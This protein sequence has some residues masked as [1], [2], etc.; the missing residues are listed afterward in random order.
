MVSC[1][2]TLCGFLSTASRQAPE[3]NSRDF[4]SRLEVLARTLIADVFGTEQHPPIESFVNQFMC[5]AATMIITSQVAYS[6]IEQDQSAARPGEGD[7][8]I[9]PLIRLFEGEPQPSAFSPAGL[10]AAVN[11]VTAEID[12]K[13]PEGE[14]PLAF[15]RRNSA[16]CTKIR[17]AM[18]ITI[19]HRIVF[20]VD[21]AL[22]GVG[23]IHCEVGDQVWVLAGAKTPVVLRPS[24]SGCYQLLGE[25]YVHGVMEGQALDYGLPLEDLTLE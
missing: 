20:R 3:V 19:D 21:T 14:N 9:S 6:Q 23:P 12:E 22:L 8:R 7:P 16:L 4:Q 17:D 18:L 13:M 15:W 5:H 10:E 11:A 25:A 1:L 2:S 24:G